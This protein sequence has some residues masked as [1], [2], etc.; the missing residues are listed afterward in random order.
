M[1]A[2]CALLVLTGITGCSSAQQPAPPEGIDTPSEVTAI[3]DHV[4]GAMSRDGL[5]TIGTDPSYPPMEFVSADGASVEGADIDLASAVATVLG[6]RPDFEDEAFSALNDSV[7]TG[8]TELAVSS[9]TVPPDQP[10]R[11]DAVLYFRSANQLVAGD[12]APGLTPKNLCGRTITTLEGSTQ[13]HSLTDLSR[14][15]RKQGSEGITIEALSDQDQVTQAV[16]TDRVDGMLSDTPIAQFA[17]TQHPGRLSLAGQ[18]FD[19]AP[20]GMLTP[21]EFSRFTKAV[22]AAVQHLIDTGYYQH[23]LD[24]W[25]IADGA[26]ERATIRWNARTQVRIDKQTRHVTGRAKR[27]SESWH[28]RTGH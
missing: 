27:Q 2:A 5:L 18:P 7:R 22:R 6:L 1:Q 23:V 25:G 13:V 9:L 8:R 16:L 12:A 20:F 17:V 4:P 15:C 11:S 19:P 24:R 21:P 28:R 14:E 26:V 3:S 10:T